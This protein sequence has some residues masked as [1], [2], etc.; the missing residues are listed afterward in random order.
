MFQNK[1]P[2]Y[3]EVLLVEKKNYIG[4]YYTNGSFF[5]YIYII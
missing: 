1:V 4:S 3:I 5:M 2:R